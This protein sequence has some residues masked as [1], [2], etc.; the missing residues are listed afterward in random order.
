MTKKLN[1]QEDAPAGGQGKVETGT[2]DINSRV[3]KAI[4]K[5]TGEAIRSR[6]SIED[7]LAALRKQIA[8][9]SDTGKVPFTPKF[10]ALWDLVEE[11]IQKGKDMKKNKIP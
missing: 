5:G 4:D 8:A 9:I 1:G 10:Q 7:E 2:V 11:E 6:I 3:E